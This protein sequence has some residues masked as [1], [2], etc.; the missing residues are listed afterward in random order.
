M[1]K[2]LKFFQEENLIE[3]IEDDKAEL[4][5]F[6]Q[7]LDKETFSELMDVLSSVLMD[8]T[9]I[10][11][12]DDHEDELEYDSEIKDAI[13]NGTDLED[14]SD[15]M[16]ES[17]V[18]SFGELLSERGTTPA[19]ERIAAARERKKDPRIKKMMRIKNAW[20]KKCKKRKLN[21]QKQASGKWGCGKVDKALS[22][23]MKKWQHGRQKSVKV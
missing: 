8:P 22:I 19:A 10:G 20:I 9:H 7:G 11:E 1:G 6:I 21:A 13:E 12:E 4:I 16:A 5:D 15:E 23:L 17:L 14:I 18:E 3:S 2:F